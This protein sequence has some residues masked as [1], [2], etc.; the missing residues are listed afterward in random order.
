MLRSCLEPSGLD[1]RRLVVSLWPSGTFFGLLAD[2]NPAGLQGQGAAQSGRGVGCKTAR[3][4]DLCVLR[5]ATHFQHS[6]PDICSCQKVGVAEGPGRKVSWDERPLQSN[7]K[8]R[9]QST[10]RKWGDSR[11]KIVPAKK[12]SHR[13]VLRRNSSGEAM[14]R[15]PNPNERTSAPIDS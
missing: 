15:A 13:S 1:P 11:E 5:G 9:L 3:T 4:V 10:F 2:L 14:N 7:E 12:H 8:F 6:T